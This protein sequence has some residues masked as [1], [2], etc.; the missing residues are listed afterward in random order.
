MARLMPSISIIII[1][2]TTTTTTTTTTITIAGCSDLFWRS[3]WL[4]HASVQAMPSDTVG[5]RVLR[6]RLCTEVQNP[7]AGGW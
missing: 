7:L 2:I 6:Y 1:I 5:D 4:I 3:S